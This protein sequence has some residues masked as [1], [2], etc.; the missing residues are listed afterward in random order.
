[1]IAIF[2]AHDAQVEIDNT[3]DSNDSTKLENREFKKWN[4]EKIDYFD[5]KY[6]DSDNHN[7][8]L[9]VNFEKN[10]YYRDVYVFVDRLKNLASLREFEKLRIVISQCL[11]DS[12]LIWHSSKLSNQKKILF[13]E[14]SLKEWYE[15]L[16]FKFKER[17][18]QTM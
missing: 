12:T 10:F 11:R 18:S 4:F 17:V 7:S 5:S 6:D 8:S 1:M 2:R 16:I 15:A 9:L 14:I 13:R 3:N